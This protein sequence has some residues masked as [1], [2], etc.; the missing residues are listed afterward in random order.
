MNNT[1]FHQKEKRKIQ[2]VSQIN[3]IRSDLNRFHIDEYHNLVHMQYIAH[4]TK[5]L[6]EIERILKDI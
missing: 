2:I 3:F 4:I 6:N 5:S 1:K